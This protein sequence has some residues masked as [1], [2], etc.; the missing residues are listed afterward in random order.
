MMTTLSI[1]LALRKPAEVTCGTA[2]RLIRVSAR[3]EDSRR[4]YNAAI[5]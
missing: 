2:P 4:V 5:P 3:V 1:R